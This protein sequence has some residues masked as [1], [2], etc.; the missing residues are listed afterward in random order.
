VNGSLIAPGEEFSLLKTL[1]VI[2]GE[3]GWF[4]ELVIKGNETKPEFGGGLCQIGTTT[5]R[6]ALNSG[7][8]ITMRQNH[9]Y[10]VRYYEP[11]GT[12]AT[13]YDP[14]PDFRFINDTGHYILINTDIKGDN[15]I[16]EVWGTKDG[17]SV[18][19][20][21]SRVYNIVAAPPMKLVETLE[22]PPGKK[23]CTETEHAGA[24]AEFTYKVT[25][26]DGKVGEEIF[27]SHYR[28][29]QAVCLIGVETLSNAQA[30]STIE[31]TPLAP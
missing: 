21:K 24:D 3:N 31:A 26:A 1:G 20:I 23:K 12:D 2:D 4:P 14:L 9:S 10:R 22:L 7:L 19:P 18:N 27:K 25:Y 17:R 8:D 13:I 5:F 6:A 16:F 15:L 29:W 11:A 30:S 28:P